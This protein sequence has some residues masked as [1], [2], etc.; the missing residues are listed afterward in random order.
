MDDATLTYHLM[1]GL[2]AELQDTWGMD[3]SDSQD[4]QFVANWAMKK[5]TKMAAIKHMRHGTISEERT[6]SPRTP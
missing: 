5:E 1:R 6:A 4:P 3:G 2:K